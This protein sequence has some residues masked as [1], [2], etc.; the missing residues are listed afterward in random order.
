MKY[1]PVFSVSKW[2]ES[3][4]PVKFGVGL[5]ATKG[6]LWAIAEPALYFFPV[7]SEHQSI[8]RLVAY[9]LFLLISL[10]GGAYAVRPRA[11]LK[12]ALKGRNLD[13]EVRVADAL[14]MKGALVVPTNVYFIADISGRMTR[15]NSIQGALIR[16]YY[17]GRAHLLQTDINQWLT[18][19]AADYEA[20]VE[21]GKDGKEYKNYGIGSVVQ[22]RKDNRLFYL[23]ANTDISFD[24]VASSTETDLEVALRHLWKY[25]AQKG[26]YSEI[27]IPLVGSQHGRMSLVREQILQVILRSFIDSC[28]KRIFCKKLTVSVFPPDV[29]SNRIDLAIA[30]DI[31]RVETQVPKY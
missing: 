15:A 9:V 28:K 26:H 21:T 24:G 14:E 5:L 18:E 2:K 1:H 7:L 30:D 12:Y 4:S 31:L 25:I 22:V 20:T 27:V 3:F 23:I 13:I 11:I 8:P 16:R 19:N 6:L 29:K 10:I 17:G